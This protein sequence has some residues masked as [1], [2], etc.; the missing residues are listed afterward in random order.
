MM[1]NDIDDQ[2]K[3]GRNVLITKPP[4]VHG[5]SVNKALSFKWDLETTKLAEHREFTAV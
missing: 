1:V 5:C 4:V 2:V 3:H